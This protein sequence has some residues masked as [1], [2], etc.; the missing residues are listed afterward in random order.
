M[1]MLRSNYL[2]YA[3]LLT[4]LVAGASSLNAQAAKK[5]GPESKKVPAQNLA[6]LAIVQPVPK[7]TVELDAKKREVLVTFSLQDFTLLTTAKN[8]SV[9]IKFF[10]KKGVVIGQKSLMF[11]DEAMPALSGGKVYRRRFGIDLD[12]AIAARVERVEGLN[13]KVDIHKDAF[14]NQEKVAAPIV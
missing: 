10:D 11:T 13:M 9:D 12:A 6:N 1:G 14:A 7:W 4:L 8:V 5:D 2:P 3:S